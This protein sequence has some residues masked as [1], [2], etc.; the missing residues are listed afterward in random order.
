MPCASCPRARPSL[1]SVDV[2]AVANAEENYGLEMD[3]LRVRARFNDE[4]PH[5]ARR[6][7]AAVLPGG[8]LS[9]DRSSLVAHYGRIGRMARRPSSWP[10]IRESDGGISGTQSTSCGGFRLKSIRDWNARWF[11]RGQSLSRLA[12]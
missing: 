4:G 2:S 1:C 8:L 3:D 10:L 9:S 11:V 12:A 5:T 7:T 6:P